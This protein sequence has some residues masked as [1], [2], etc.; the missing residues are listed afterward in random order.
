WHGSDHGLDIGFIFGAPFRD[1]YVSNASD[2]QLLNE[3]RVSLSA[4]ETV[5]NFARYG[6]PGKQE[7]I[8]WQPYYE[9]N[10]KDIINPYFEFT[11]RYFSDSPFGVGF[12][13]EC[14]H[15]WHKYVLAN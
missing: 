6:N 8:E 12:K 2:S 15:F 1:T 13:Y 9:T 14:N 7:S 10:K 3:R 5:A 11:R 4:M